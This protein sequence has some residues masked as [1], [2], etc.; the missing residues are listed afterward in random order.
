VNGLGFDRSHNIVFLWLCNVFSHI[1]KY[2][3]GKNGRLLS[4]QD[5]MKTERPAVDHIL[6]HSTCYQHCRGNHKRRRIYMISS[7]RISSPSYPRISMSKN[8]DNE[9]LLGQGSSNGELIAALL[10]QFRLE[11]NTTSI[12]PRPV[13]PLHT[14]FFSYATS[15]C[16]IQFPARYTT[17]LEC[18]AISDGSVALTRVGYFSRLCWDTK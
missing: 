4:I 13:G 2:H 1:E 15:S 17:I 11:L 3:P 18:F 5:P 7:S 14:S 10:E 16:S 6:Y 9:I 12:R 8:A